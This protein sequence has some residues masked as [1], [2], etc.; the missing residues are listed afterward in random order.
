MFRL[1]V[2][3]T[4][5]AMSGSAAGQLDETDKKPLNEGKLGIPL[6]LLPRDKSG[7]ALGKSFDWLVRQ[8]HRDGGWSFDAATRGFAKP[9]SNLSRVEATA[10]AMLTLMGDG[11]THKKGRY[12]AIVKKGLEFLRGEMKPRDGTV[13]ARG[14]HGDLNAHALSTLVL[15]QLY[16]MTNDADLKAKVVGCL[17]H[18][19]KQQDPKT[20]GWARAPNEPPT[21]DAHYWPVM[22]IYSGQQAKLVEAGKAQ[23]L[24]AIFL[25]A[26]RLDGGPFYVDA[27]GKKSALATAQALICRLYLGERLSST[28]TVR[29]AKYLLDKGPVNH[30]AAYNFLVR[31]LL[32]HHQ[33]EAWNTWNAAHRGRLLAGQQQTGLQAG[34]WYDAQDR[35]A[36]QGG[37]LYQTTLHMM[38]LELYYRHLPFYAL[39]WQEE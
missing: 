17:A 15:C 24:A 7:T 39:T 38:S 8:Q 12:E 32:Y 16:E 1:V 20:G 36:K 29:G 28:A 37:Q 26:L 31:L 34:S 11:N 19:I 5:L 6:Q 2:W 9:G 13:D 21:L 3:L 27:N 22:A 4:I 14:A 30:D 33:G 23:R 10:M 18:L 35:G 25:D